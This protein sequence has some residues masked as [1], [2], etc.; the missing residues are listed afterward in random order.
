MS[1]CSPI[2]ENKSYWY[3]RV[4][5]WEHRFLTENVQPHAATMGHSSD[6]LSS[7][8]VVLCSGPPKWG[9]K[10]ALGSRDADGNA[11]I[12]DTLSFPQQLVPIG[13]VQNVQVS[14]QKQIQQ[15]FEIGSRE[16][17]F[18]PGRT[19]VSMG[20]SRILFDGPSLMYA[21]YINSVDHPEWQNSYTMRP[22]ARWKGQGKA[23]K[24]TRPDEFI[25]MCSDSEDGCRPHIKKYDNGVLKNAKPGYFFSNLASSFF[26]NSTGLGLVM[27]DSE[28]EPY[29]GFF[30][31]KCFIQSHSFSVAAAQTVLM[32]NVSVRCGNLI[33]IS[34]E[35]LGGTS[36][37]MLDCD[38]ETEPA[39]PN[40]TGG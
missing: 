31:E 6:F 19:M 21:M 15:L 7:E 40:F 3:K 18:I 33:P 8:T 34:A 2:E 17:F 30:L 9:P 13:L 16:P 28:N 27:F 39:E 14:Q 10:Q 23:D 4:G 11:I 25:D 35:E 29:G 22:Y 1:K 36:L 12:T 37:E 26:N 20:M 38:A 5:D 32:E 24:P